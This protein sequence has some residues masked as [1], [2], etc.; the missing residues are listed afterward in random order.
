MSCPSPDDCLDEFEESDVEDDACPSPANCEDDNDSLASAT[1]H[2]MQGDGGGLQDTTTEDGPAN[3]DD[4]APDMQDTETNGNSG[5]YNSGATSSGSTSGSASGNPATE[6]D[7]TGSS[8]NSHN[9][10]LIAGIIGA[11]VGGL[12][13]VGVVVFMVSK[14][15]RRSTNLNSGQQVTQ[16]HSQIEMA[17]V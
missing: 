12:L 3:E 8:G 1:E 17:Y 9:P 13:L 14:R 7:S 10:H 2:G 15:G 4:Y 11:V 16:R 5:G 6:A